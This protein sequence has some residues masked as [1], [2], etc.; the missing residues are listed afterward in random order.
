MLEHAK[1]E[2]V[3]SG[4]LLGDGGEMLEYAKTEKWMVVKC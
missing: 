2:K 3:D 1:T 4:S